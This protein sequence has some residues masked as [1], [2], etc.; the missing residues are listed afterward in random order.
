MA[1]DKQPELAKVQSLHVP[2]CLYSEFC[3]WMM[4][5]LEDLLGA[6]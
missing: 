4:S 2:A 1:E 6:R 3:R 5:V